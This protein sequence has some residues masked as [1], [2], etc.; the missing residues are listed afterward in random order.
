MPM[1]QP[2]WL[3]AIILGVLWSFPLF[4]LSAAE[5]L[6]PA[7]LSDRVKTNVMGHLTHLVLA[8]QPSPLVDPNVDDPAQ[9][10]SYFV[11]PS[12]QLGLPGRGAAPEV[13]RPAGLP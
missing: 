4:G 8:R 1:N 9:P 10:F 5:P 11:T 2:G 3:R 13:P 7:R 6:P 12:T